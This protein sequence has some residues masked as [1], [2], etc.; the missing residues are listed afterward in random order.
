MKKKTKILAIAA[1]AAL[2]V[3]AAVGC[4]DTNTN[5]ADTSTNNNANT[6]SDEEPST[7]QDSGETAEA[8]AEVVSISGSELE[9]RFYLADSGE[10]AIEDYAAIDLNDYTAE[11]ETST[12]AIADDAEV[13]AVTSGELADA[14][15]EDVTAG[16][17]LAV[18]YTG[19]EA[20]K[21]VILSDAGPEM[22]VAEVTGTSEDGQ[23]SLTYY[24]FSGDASEE[25]PVD[26]ANV[27]LSSYEATEDTE[28]Y[29]VA[30]GTLVS[31]AENGTLTET[32]AEEIAVGDIL[33]FYPTEDGQTAIAV[34][35]TLSEPVLDS[36]T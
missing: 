13:L 15:L 30:D 23:L 12:L 25:Y 4:S 1:M 20:S 17:Y 26:Y 29:A 9:V 21:L 5:N 36:E 10:E 8:V 7:G 11:E 16:S 35:H 27:D 14:A 3:G 31:V 18:T 22:L 33:V 34:Y 24:A 6:D 28:E 19:D 32:T 2:L